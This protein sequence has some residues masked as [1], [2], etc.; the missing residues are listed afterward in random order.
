MKKR[1]KPARTRTALIVVVGAVG[2]SLPVSWSAHAAGAAVASLARAQRTSVNGRAALAG[3]TLLNN[4]RL[5]T[6]RDG[7]ALARIGQAGAINL[8]GESELALRLADG[9]VGGELMAGRVLA[10]ARAGARLEIQVLGAKVLTDGKQ[11][12]AIVVEVRGRG[13]R[14]VSLLN[15]AQVSVNGRPETVKKCQVVDV[16]EEGN[17]RKVLP[18][19]IIAAGGGLGTAATLAAVLN[20]SRASGS[21]GSVPIL[22]PPIAGG[23]NPSPTNP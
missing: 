16:I 19:G 13:V 14:L 23:L 15:D 4:A 2:I 7:T 20:S 17:R 22:P 11:A 3:A 1:M 12:G 18:V 8:D 9:V 5:K 10:T 6:E 21:A